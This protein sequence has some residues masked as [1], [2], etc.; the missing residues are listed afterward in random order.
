MG[1]KS[2]DI[3]F[4]MVVAMMVTSIALSSY[5]LYFVPREAVEARKREIAELR[6]QEIIE[7]STKSLNIKNTIEKLQAA[8]DKRT[9]PLIPPEKLTTI[10]EYIP[11]PR[12]TF[13]TM[14]GSSWVQP[15]WIGAIGLL[16]SLREVRTQVP[17]FIVLLRLNN[18]EAFPVQARYVLEKLG[19]RIVTV[20]DI[21][22]PSFVSIP[23]VW[24]LFPPR[25]GSLSL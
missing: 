12:H 7:H 25:S 3:F 14:A 10:G 17:N 23:S 4:Y 1:S 24:G 19:A 20:E 22:L 11:D 6:A 13:A 9:M 5:F 16:Q 2:A 15:Y 8:A 21:P 18:R